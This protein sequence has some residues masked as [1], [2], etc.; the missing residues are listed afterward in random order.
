MLR[1]YTCIVCPNGCALTVSD[2]ENA[3]TVTGA[4]C[5]RGRDY[6]IAET[7]NPCRNI[8]SSVRVTGGELPLA[9]VRL[10]A[11]IPRARIMDAMAQIR[12]VRLAAPVRVG[13]VAIRNL[14]GLGVDVVA[15]KG[16]DR[17]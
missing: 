14:L 1:E 10:T 6:A 15:T 8:A 3:L 7:E 13:Q 11:P 5:P 16:V 4:L 9:S 17:R 2:G 12:R